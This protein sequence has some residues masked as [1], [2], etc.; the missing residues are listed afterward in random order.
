MEEEEQIAWTLSLITSVLFELAHWACIYFV[1][2]QI[3]KQVLYLL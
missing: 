1:I 2:K 3:Q